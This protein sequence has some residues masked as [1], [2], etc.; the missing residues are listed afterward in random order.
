[1]DGVL[2][3]HGESL[4]IALEKIEGTDS[5]SLLS[6]GDCCDFLLSIKRRHSLEVMIEG[7]VSK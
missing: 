6:R 4:S 7:V 1:M 2:S 3:G 5:T